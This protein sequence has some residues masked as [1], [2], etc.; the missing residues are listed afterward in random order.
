[1]NKGLYYNLLRN[2]FLSEDSLFI[3]LCDKKGYNDC[4]DELIRMIFSIK[5]MPQNS[6]RFEICSATFGSDDEYEFKL[7]VEYI[8]VYVHKFKVNGLQN[9]HKPFDDLKEELDEQTKVIRR[10]NKIDEIVK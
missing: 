2:H 9:F 10:N 3:Y 8:C 5:D 4:G 7:F 6:C 1:M